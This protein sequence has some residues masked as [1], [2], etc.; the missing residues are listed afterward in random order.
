L[1]YAICV[2]GPETPRRPFDHRTFDELVR[3]E[4]QARRQAEHDA[5]F[6]RGDFATR[7]VAIAAV[8][9]V[10]A[11]IGALWYHAR[12]GITAAPHGSTSVREQR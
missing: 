1:C 8:L 9:A 11:W 2:L 6:S 10:A 3:D 7:L 4:E 12:N 5:R